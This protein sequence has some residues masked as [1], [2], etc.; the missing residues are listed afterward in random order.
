MQVPAVQT[1][2][3]TLFAEM[4]RGMA[5]NQ[6]L[7]TPLEAEEY[8]ICELSVFRCELGANSLDT[9]KT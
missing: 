4:W 5:Q 1:S 3:L 6:L 9:I 7:D 2:L 8:V